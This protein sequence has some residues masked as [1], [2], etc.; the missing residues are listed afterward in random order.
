[1]VKAEEKYK[2]DKDTEAFYS[3]LSENVFRI[4]DG[5]LAFPYKYSIG[6]GIIIELLGIG[7]FMFSFFENKKA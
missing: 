4:P 5:G 6:I 3:Q 1:M 7:F 2:A